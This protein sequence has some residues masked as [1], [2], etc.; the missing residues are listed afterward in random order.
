MILSKSGIAIVGLSLILLAAAGCGGG[1]SES[2]PVLLITVDGLAADQLSLFEGEKATPAL[3]QLAADG[4]VYQEAWTASPMTRPAVATYL[5][6]IAP[7]RH[8][9]RDDIYSAL[10]EE[11][12]TLAALL[13]EK[14]YRTAAF[15]N[16]SFLGHASGLLRG[17]ELADEPPAPPLGPERMMP[18]VRA[19]RTSADNFKLWT[20]G[21]PEG[22]DYFAWFHF[23]GPQLDQLESFLKSKAP[24]SPMKGK[25]KRLQGARKA[26]AVEGSN[27]YWVD[28]SAPE[29][30]RAKGK[31]KGVPPD[32]GNAVEAFDAALLAIL[33]RLEERGELQD[34]LIIVA[35]TQADISGGAYEARGPGFSLGEP[36]IRVPLIVRFPA[37]SAKPRAADE[38][39]WAPD[40]A[41]TIA[42]LAGVALA[43][44]SEGLSLMR[45]PE[46]D[47]IIY[48]WSWATLDQMGW[49]PLRAARMGNAKLLQGVE[50]QL[51]SLDGEEIEESSETAERL[52]AA[53]SERN[54]LQPQIV[55]LD[56]ARP[57]LEGRGIKLDPLPAAGR[58]FMDMQK[59]RQA[60]DFLWKGRICISRRYRGKIQLNYETARS[61]DPDAF[62]PL[63]EFGHYYTLAWDEDAE[64]KMRMAVEKYPYSFDALHWYVHAI[65]QESWAEAEVMV[66]TLLTYRPQD[67]DLLYDK[68]CARSLAGDIPLS[69]EFL[70]TAI[71][72]G[73]DKWNIIQ[74]DRDLRNLRETPEFS[75]L[76][77]NYG[78]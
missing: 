68:A 49:L 63:F 44:E 50:E 40:V 37:G 17:F 70:E 76:L 15:P 61:A 56:L 74:G 41:A 51:I 33:D 53:I 77:R 7:D 16:S 69:V 71:Q 62:G 13:T 34:A 23:S 30:A 25:S 58:S 55:D 21:L 54:E 73:F 11:I 67:M 38:T 32:S 43:D 47:R 26:K 2:M 10:P 42:D 18:L 64:T 19:A 78:R 57:W 35:A 45:T 31:G 60:S 9:M 12:P 6:G 75:E 65:W 24:D 29:G 36:A 5:T 8:G 66:D 46:S 22:S 14:G 4:V 39:V 1:R 52:L 48:S 27:D 3:E 28:A 20:D 72:A 59:R